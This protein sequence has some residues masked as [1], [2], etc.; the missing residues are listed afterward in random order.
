MSVRP[1]IAAP[2]T[3]IRLEGC[4]EPQPNLMSFEIGDI[5]GP[6]LADLV[7]VHLQVPGGRREP[8]VGELHVDAGAGEQRLTQERIE[9]DAFVAAQV[10]RF[11]GQEDARR[12]L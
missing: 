3:S 2:S 7:P 6:V 1:S 10:P 12:D 5:Q 11:E 8:M 4:T 9:A